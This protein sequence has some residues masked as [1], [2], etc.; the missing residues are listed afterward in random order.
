L[1]QLLDVDVTY[2][3]GPDDVQDGDVL[4]YD[5][6]AKKWVA[7]AGGA[8]S[9]GFS[10]I[11]YTGLWTSG[12]VS[13]LEVEWNLASEP[14]LALS[15]SSGGSL[16]GSVQ[17]GVEVTAPGIYMVIATVAA[18]MG[19]GSGT[20]GVSIL[21]TGAT[22]GWTIDGDAETCRPPIHA[23][24]TGDNAAGVPLLLPLDPETPVAID[25][26]LG[27]CTEVRWRLQ[28][29]WR[30]AAAVEPGACGG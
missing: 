20:P 27:G 23:A 9:R 14:G 18:T 8:G 28:V 1:H 29:D 6:E 17:E 7:A 11:S 22:S 12:G 15:P 21:H 19:G 16:L 24:D 4:T 5:D 10:T 13:D 26:D 2:G 25:V 3:D 30:H